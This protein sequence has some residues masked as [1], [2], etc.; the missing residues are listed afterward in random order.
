MG[1]AILD[2]ISKDSTDAEW[3]EWLQAP[4]QRAAAN[5][6]GPLSLALLKAGATGCHLHP[7][8]RGGQQELLNK[9]LELGASASIRDESGN[10]PIHVAAS[11]GHGDIVGTLLA[12]EEVDANEENGKGW[13]PMQLTCSLGGDVHTAKV[14]LDAG[15]KLCVRLG[16]TKTGITALDLAARSG[17][18]GVMTMLREAG[19]PDE[20]R[21]ST[22]GE[23]LHEAATENNAPMIDFLVIEAKT[24]V[25]FKD[26]RVRK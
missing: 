26:G 23:I 14:L 10:A 24:D 6:D 13:T 5:G 2:V 21:S 25:N 4:F 12:I 9:L 22:D 16:E 3:G 7:A 20:L 1:D 11:V 8:I 15:A 18:E 17:H 19:V